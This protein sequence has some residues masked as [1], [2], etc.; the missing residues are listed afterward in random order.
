VLAGLPALGGTLPPTYVVGAAPVN[1][2]EGIGL[3]P[4][5]SEAV[6]AAALAVQELLAVRPW[7]R[8]RELVSEG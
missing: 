6:P 2:D 1:L 4:S 3:G 5:M 8:H 7:A